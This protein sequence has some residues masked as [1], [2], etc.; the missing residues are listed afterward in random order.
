MYLADKLELQEATYPLC[1]ILPFSTKM[2]APLKL[3]YV[4]INTTGGLFG[5][6]HTARGH[7]FHRSEISGEPAAARCYHLQTSRG[8]QTEEG[9]HLGN[10]LASY[11]HLHFASEPSLAAAFLQRCQDFQASAN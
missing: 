4:E 5:P 7:L 9:Y 8:D 6:G 2:P 11:V 10:V 1:G 3:A